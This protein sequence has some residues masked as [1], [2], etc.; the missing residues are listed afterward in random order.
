MVRRAELTEKQARFAIDH[1]EYPDEVT[2]AASCVAVVMTQDWCPQ[3]TAMDAYLR[4]LEK[5]GGDEG[6]QTIEVYELIYNTVSYFNEF[7]RFK[8]KK[9]SNYQIPYVRYYRDGKLVGESN[10]V[11]KDDFLRR[12]AR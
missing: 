9:W 1:G 4:S 7:R 11:M 2:C 10:F 12:C 6:E 8:E 3:W 5:N